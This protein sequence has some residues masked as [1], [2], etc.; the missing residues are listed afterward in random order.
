MPP[1]QPKPAEPG[2]TAPPGTVP[3][4]ISKSAGKKRRRV[5]PDSDATLTSM[6]KIARQSG[7]PSTI[8]SAGEAMQHGTPVNPVQCGAMA[9]VCGYCEKRFR[10]PSKLAQHERVDHTNKDAPYYCSFC[11]KTFVNQSRAT[12]HERTHTGEK[13]YACPQVIL[14]DTSA[15]ILRR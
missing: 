3:V 12:A 11:P 10:S 4:A 7:A 2:R 14:R 9:H 1:A 5:A 13:P 6:K 15:L 8:A